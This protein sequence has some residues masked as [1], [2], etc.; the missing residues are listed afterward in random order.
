MHDYS[1]LT[2]CSTIIVTTVLMRSLVTLPL[3]VYTNRI[4]ARLEL[5]S[6]ELPALADEL[7]GEVALAKH[8]Y[9]LDDQKCSVL[10][11]RSLKKQWDKLV[12][13]ENC[14][15]VKTMIVLWG[16]IPLWICQSMA[17]RN[18]VN[19]MPDPTSTAAK[20]V[21]TQLAVGGCAWFPD[22]TAADSTLIMPIVLCVLNLMN[23]EFHTLE[24]TGPDSRFRNAATIFFRL[25]SIALI[26]IAAS[27]PSSLALYWTTSSAYSLIQNVIMVSP[28][29]KRFLRIP[30]NTPSH[31]EQPYSVIAER[32]LEKWR[33]RKW[34]RFA[35]QTKPIQW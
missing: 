1:G 9:K 22:L 23:I 12:V 25:I 14:H 33:L 34:F 16:Q 7:R 30:T 17:I 35:Q 29:V 19:L 15:P 2:W 26:P 5:I 28:G 6:L 24:K 3:A 11:R 20:E 31:L 27:V 8:L 10:Y 4:R 21:L 13:R 18:M 32:F